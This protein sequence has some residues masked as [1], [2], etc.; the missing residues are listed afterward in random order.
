MIDFPEMQALVPQAGPDVRLT[1]LHR[2]HIHTHFRWNNDPELN[3][4]DSEVPFQ[5]ESF[6]TFKRRFEQLCD[7]P[8][9]THYAFE[10]HSI[11]EEELIGVASL[12]GI[13]PSNAH[14]RISI[15]IG[16]R[17][18]WGSGYG[19][20]AMSLLLSLCFD[21]V[22]LHRVS[23]ETFEFNDAWTRLVRGSGFKHE[24]TAREY[25]FRDEQFWDKDHYALLKRDYEPLEPVPV[26][27]PEK[28]EIAE[29]M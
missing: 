11:A 23:A 21:K 22:G 8:E 10:I 28:E 5:K 19:R 26:Q 16:N 3:R 20:G 14:G 27:P 9:E 24:G 15:T 25:L 12:Y 13:S 1:A 29:V 18:Y 6:G 2:D 7:S 4:L 17:S